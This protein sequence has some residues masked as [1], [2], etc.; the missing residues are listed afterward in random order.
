MI[1]MGKFTLKWRINEKGL[2]LV[3]VL[4]S[5]VILT[6][7]LT[8]FLMMFVQSAKTNKKSEEIIDA[9]Y[10]AQTEMENIYAASKNSKFIDRD[11]E[12]TKLQFN[13][14]DSKIY[15][16]QQDNPY[17]EVVLEKIEEGK[18]PIKVLVKVYNDKDEMKLEAQMETILLWGADDK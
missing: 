12:M 6:L 4:A 14:L 11:T 1:L 18:K 13:S 17:I 16:S 15:T 7:L 10:V 5:I 3:E 2:S 9:T 8:T